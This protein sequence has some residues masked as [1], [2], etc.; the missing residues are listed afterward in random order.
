MVLFCSD[1]LGRFLN[2][3]AVSD[4]TSLGLT[5]PKQ[6]EN[7]AHDEHLHGFA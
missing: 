3:E 2:V 7:K 6:H 1:A 4:G 5:V